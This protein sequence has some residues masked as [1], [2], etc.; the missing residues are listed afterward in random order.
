MDWMYKYLRLFRLYYILWTTIDLLKH[1]SRR[2]VCDMVFT[3]E[4]VTWVP[5]CKEWA[6]GQE[7]MGVWGTDVYSSRSTPCCLIPGQVRRINPKMIR[8]LSQSLCRVF[9]KQDAK[10][11]KIQTITSTQS[12]HR[13]WGQWEWGVVTAGEVRAGPRGD[14][15]A[16]WQTHALLRASWCAGVCVCV[17]QQYCVYILVALYLNQRRQNHLSFGH[18]SLCVQW[19]PMEW[20]EQSKSTKHAHIPDVW[21]GMMTKQ[22]TGVRKKERGEKE[23]RREEGNN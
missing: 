18:S 16:Q 17:C 22:Q 10:D 1:S 8:H 11:K 21:C 3:D 15:P 2:P 7:G 5:V 12:L 20:A 19:N 6:E 23:K 4:S 13:T 9:L 14:R